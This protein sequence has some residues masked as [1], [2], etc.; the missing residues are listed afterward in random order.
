M[1]PLGFGCGPRWRMEADGGRSDGG[2]GRVT[3]PG[4][5]D[6]DTEKVCGRFSEPRPTSG[7]SPFE[8]RATNALACIIDIAFELTLDTRSRKPLTR[9]VQYR[10]SG[11]RDRVSS[12]S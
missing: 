5:N 8:G 11:L 7:R 2:Y 6:A 12:V 4:G 3:I 10:F 1:Q 9:I